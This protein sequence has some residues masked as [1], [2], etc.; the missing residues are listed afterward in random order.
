MSKFIFIR[1]DGTVFRNGLSFESLNV[2]LDRLDREGIGQ[3]EIANGRIYEIT[4]RYQFSP[5]KVLGIF[6]KVEAF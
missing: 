6:H 5:P 2:L 3:Q 1:P 4:G